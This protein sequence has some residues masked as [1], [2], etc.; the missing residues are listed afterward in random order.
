MIAVATVL[1]ALLLWWV[2]HRSKRLRTIDDLTANDAILIGLFQVL[3]LVPG[4]S[5]SGI[6]MTAGLMLGLSREAAARFSFLMAVPIIGAAGCLKGVD[7][8]REPELW[9]PGIFILGV[10]VNFHHRLGCCRAVHSVCRTGWN[11]S[12][13]ALS[14]G[15]GCRSAPIVLVGPLSTVHLR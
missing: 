8:L 9:Q 6:T 7:L 13:R 1:F 4:T 14:L 12:I 2:D 15:A 11:A 10:A 3:A 5:R